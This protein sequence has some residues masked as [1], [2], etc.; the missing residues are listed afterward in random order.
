MGSWAA[1]T[2]AALLFEPLSS[3]GWIC[4]AGFLNRGEIVPPVGAPSV[5]DSARDAVTNRGMGHLEKSREMGWG[6]AGKQELTYCQNS[7][8]KEKQ[9]FSEISYAIHSTQGE[10]ES[11]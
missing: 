3:V 10:P 2:K 1:K 4:S 6:H 11:L 7:E 5:C 8:F 9:F